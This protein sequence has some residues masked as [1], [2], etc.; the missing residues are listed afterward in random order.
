MSSK[1]SILHFAVFFLST[2]AAQKETPLD[3]ELH[4]ACK[5]G[6]F[7]AAKRVLDSGRVS[8]DCKDEKSVRRE[9]EG[10]VPLVQSQIMQNSDT[11]LTLATIHGHANCVQVLLE[12]E[13]DVD[14]ARNV[15]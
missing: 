10:E 3:N 11:P 2:F 6:D 1:V 7:S 8:A 12:E 14:L 4:R 5:N 13:A 15:R 9:E